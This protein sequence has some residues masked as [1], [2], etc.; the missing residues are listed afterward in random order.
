MIPI[1]A[2]ADLAE[3]DKRERPLRSCL[4]VHVYERE[5]D[6]PGDRVG[7]LVIA[8]EPSAA[9]IKLTISEPEKNGTGFRSVSIHLDADGFAALQSATYQIPTPEAKPRQEDTLKKLRFI[10]EQLVEQIKAFQTP[11]TS[12]APPTVYN[13]GGLGRLAVDIRN[14]VQTPSKNPTAEQNVL[15]GRR[16]YAPDDD[17]ESS[18]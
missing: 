16:A 8:Q 2:A 9:S 5:G 7:R 13:V 6:G 12:V 17:Q 15:T 14:A 10:N 1:A 4:A 3:R 11:P 18:L